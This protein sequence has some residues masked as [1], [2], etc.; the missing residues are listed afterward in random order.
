MP[1]NID[2]C[3]LTGRQG[4]AQDSAALLASAKELSKLL[5]TA[6]LAVVQKLSQ[7]YCQWNYLAADRSNPQSSHFDRLS[8]C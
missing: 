4:V 7:A 5:G 8:S 1:E 6:G 2:T 3:L